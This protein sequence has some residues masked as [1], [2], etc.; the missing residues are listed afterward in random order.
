[1]YTV[2]RCTVSILNTIRDIQGWTYGLNED[3]EKRRSPHLVHYALVDDAIKAANRSAAGET[4]RTLLVYGYVLDPPSGDHHGEEE[5]VAGGGGGGA[6]GG[7]G[8][9]G[10]RKGGASAP[11]CRTYR[12]EKTYGVS[13]GR[14]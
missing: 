1:M 6:G 8:G 12:L 2:R 7:G 9:E 5:G 10:D 14:W 4:V 13:A 3:T 11:H